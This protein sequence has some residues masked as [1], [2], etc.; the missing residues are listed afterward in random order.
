MNRQMHLSPDHVHRIISGATQ[1]AYHAKLK[2]SLAHDEDVSLI[3]N[4]D[5]DVRM[6]TGDDILVIVDKDRPPVATLTVA[7]IDTRP[8]YL[9]DMT[10]ISS[11]KHG[12]DNPCDLWQMWT[13]RYDASAFRWWNQCQKD[14]RAGEE[15][16][17]FRCF[18]KT[19]NPALYRTRTLHVVL[20]AVHI[21]VQGKA[22]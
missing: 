14:I 10:T 3:T 4:E 19:R 9:F 22:S 12:Y 16:R 1:M 2:H 17:V 18:L 5:G 20:K 7:R 8:V 6:A 15:E 13:A 21:G 11:T